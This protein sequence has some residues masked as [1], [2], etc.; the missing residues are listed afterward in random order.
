[1]LG[2]LFQLLV[3]IKSQ[4]VTLKPNLRYGHTATLINDKLYSIS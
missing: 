1:M 4:A 3:E 2:T